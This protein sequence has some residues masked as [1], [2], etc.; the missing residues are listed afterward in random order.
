MAEAE[1]HLEVHPVGLIQAEV[2]AVHIHRIVGKAD[3][4]L[5]ADG[6]TKGEKV[7]EVPIVRKEVT[8]QI[9][10]GMANRLHRF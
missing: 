7:R 3:P 10:E 9:T 2:Q 4:H 8:G 5:G 6:T 1:G